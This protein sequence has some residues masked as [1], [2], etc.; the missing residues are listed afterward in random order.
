MSRTI[1]CS[2]GVALAAEEAI[3]G[4][5]TDTTSGVGVSVVGIRD[6]ALSVF[7]VTIVIYSLLWGV[8]EVGVSVSCF[9][10]IDGASV[11]IGVGGMIG[12]FSQSGLGSSLS[13]Q[14]H[15]LTTPCRQMPRP[16]QLAGQ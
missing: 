6:G 13:K 14:S 7:E 12:E 3:F 8:S 1:Q 4:S 9:S 11:G 10:S 15:P 16:E 5:L 2:I